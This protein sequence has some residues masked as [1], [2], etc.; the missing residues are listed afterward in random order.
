MSEVGKKPLGL[1]MNMI[2]AMGLEVTYAYDDLVFVA[3]NAFVLQMADDPKLVHLYFNQTSLPEHHD[4]L[5]EKLSSHAKTNGLTINRAGLFT[6]EQQPDS[7][8]F[9]INFLDDKKT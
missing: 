6:T 5:T 2:E 3:H 7:E 1:I 8:E 4:A 9:T